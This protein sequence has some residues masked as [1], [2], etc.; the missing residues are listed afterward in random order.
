ME[1]GERHFKAREI[2]PVPWFNEDRKIHAVNHRQERTNVSLMDRAE[3]IPDLGS[4]SAFTYETGLNFDRNP[5]MERWVNPR[6][7]VIG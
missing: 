7:F 1:T 2:A 5:C 3:A 4:C 6:E